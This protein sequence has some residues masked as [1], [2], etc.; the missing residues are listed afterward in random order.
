MRVVNLRVVALFLFGMFAM[1]MCPGS[2]MVSSSV[3]GSCSGQPVWRLYRSGGSK[4]PVCIF[5]TGERNRYST[6]AGSFSVTKL[7]G[8]PKATVTCKLWCTNRTRRQTATMVDNAIREKLSAKCNFD[9][10]E[11]VFDRS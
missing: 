10:E 9:F 4:R 2:S 11:D 3:N 5:G 7:L 8:V 1:A 6:S